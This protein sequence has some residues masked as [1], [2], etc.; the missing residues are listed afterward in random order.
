MIQ[1]ETNIDRRREIESIQYFVSEGV[2]GQAKIFQRALL[3][4]LL[5]LR[6]TV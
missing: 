2:L 6:E 1:N 5:L 3:Q 4:R